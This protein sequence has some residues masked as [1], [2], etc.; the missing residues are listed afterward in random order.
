MILL[1]TY[2]CTL[3]CLVIL[4]TSVHGKQST[5]RKRLARVLERVVTLE[6]RGPV[7]LDWDG[8]LCSGDVGE[9]FFR[10]MLDNE[11][12]PRKRLKLLRQRVED[13][14]QGKL[15]SEA[16]Y[17]LMVTSLAGLQEARVKVLARAYFTAHH[18]DKIY[19]PMMWFVGALKKEGFTPWVVSGSPYW[20]VAAGAEHFGIPAERVIGL[21]V[22]VDHQGRLTDELKS[23]IPWKRG[24]AAA[25]LEQIG[26]APIISAGNSHGDLWMMKIT[27]ALKIVVNPGARVLKEALARGWF[28]QTLTTADTLATAAAAP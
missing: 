24:K 16:F 11:H 10:W 7:T 21:R 26:R 9:G 4:C 3:L 25:I 6:R 12:Y 17:N 8:T 14:E 13:Y 5:A 15:P 27:R 22:R 20:V 2:L 19:R 23:P 1:K 18:Q 28:V